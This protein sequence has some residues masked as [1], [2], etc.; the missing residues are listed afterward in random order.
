MATAIRL[1]ESVHRRLHQAASERDVSANLLVTRAVCDYLDRLPS[2]DDA[3][4]AGRPGRADGTTMSDTPVPGVRNG[5]PRRPTATANFGSGRREAHDAS[6]FYD[7]FVAPEVSDR[8]DGRPRRRARRHLHPRRPAHGHGRVRTRWRSS[9]RRR[10]TSPASSTRRASASTACRPP[11]SS[12][13]SCCA[14]CSPSASGC[15]SRAAA[16]PST[17]P[18]SGRRPYR[19][20]SGDVTEILQ[21]LGLLLRGEVDLVEGPGGR[22]LVRLGHVPAPVEPGAARHH[23][24]GRDRQQGPLRPGA[25]PRAAPRRRA[26]VDGH[27]LT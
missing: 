19:S 4:S 1:P 5:R 7:R 14:T 27:D 18:T 25:Q 10:P 11:T 3:L 26:A 15:S 23:R 2:A 6:A 24:A 8:R 9:S 16:S 17:S 22:R 20:L 21:D 13:S 12:T